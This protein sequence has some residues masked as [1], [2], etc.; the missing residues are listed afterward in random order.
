M[1]HQV[2]FY[3]VY[4]LEYSK[5]VEIQMASSYFQVLSQAIISH[6]F[7]PQLPNPESSRYPVRISF[8]NV[9]NASLL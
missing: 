3:P 6:C 4:S 5:I 9:S 1:D 8:L 2:A 7:P